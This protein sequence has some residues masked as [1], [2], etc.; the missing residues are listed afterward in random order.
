M[1]TMHVKEGSGLTVGEIV[2]AMHQT[3]EFG[4]LGREDIFAVVEIFLKEYV[5][6]P[7]TMVS[8]KFTKE[9]AED[10]SKRLNMPLEQVIKIVAIFRIRAR[11]PSSGQFKFMR[12]FLK[13]KVVG[14][15]KGTI[16]R[17]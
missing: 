13:P 6:M 7:G 15:E 16:R 5:G 4:P 14:G 3:G 1:K 12:S 17:M 9:S 11:P 10:I 8:K 2:D